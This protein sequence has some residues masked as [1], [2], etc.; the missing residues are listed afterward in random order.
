MAIGLLFYQAVNNRREG[1]SE[2]AIGHKPIDSDQPQ[3]TVN[4]ASDGQSALMAGRASF[5]VT[6]KKLAVLT[7]AFIG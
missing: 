2:A 5:N 4:F 7:P 6:N 3:P 1:L